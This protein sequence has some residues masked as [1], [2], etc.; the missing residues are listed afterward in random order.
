MTEPATST[1]EWDDFA[2]VAAEER[3]SKQ[4]PSSPPAR[5]YGAVADVVRGLDDLIESLPP[6]HVEVDLIAEADLEQPP[7]SWH[8]ISDTHGWPLRYTGRL[9]DPTG[10]NWLA[11]FAMASPIIEKGGIAILHGPRGTGKTR[12]AAEIARSGRFPLDHVPG[13]GPAGAPPDPKRT[14][15]YRTAMEFFVEIRS[16]YGRNAEATEKQI[17]AMLARCGL[18]V[19]DEVQE[20]GDSLFEDRLLTHLVDRRYGAMLPTILISNHD[21]KEVGAALGT[22]II[23][24][25]WEGGKS[26][27]FNW[28]S[29]RRA[30]R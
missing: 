25:V 30:G 9:P 2:E 18:L 14:A 4:S 10:G 1:G 21:S 12:M 5:L 16:T 13:K 3:R 24:R 11:T 20:R 27:E 7:K 19:I 22:S 8:K 6:E 29:Y 17:I 23:D 15:R 28:E 26:F